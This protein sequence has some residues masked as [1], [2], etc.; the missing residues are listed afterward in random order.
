VQPWA[1][2]TAAGLSNAV[3]PPVQENA[4]KLYEAAGA[5]LNGMIVN[6]EDPKAVLQKLQDEF[7][8]QF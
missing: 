8:D 4:P 1:D 2:V 6:N 7:V 5:A 3:P